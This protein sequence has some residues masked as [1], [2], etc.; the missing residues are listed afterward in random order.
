MVLPQARASKKS[1]YREVTS[2]DVTDASCYNGTMPQEKP[3]R[4]WY[5]FSLR[6]MF[7][8]TVVVSIPL[9]WVGY[10]LN[11]IR[12]RREYRSN[13]PP[14]TTTLV[15]SCGT[16]DPLPLSLRLFGEKPAAN[17]T[18]SPRSPYTYAEAEK[19]FPESAVYK[20]P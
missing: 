15:F 10:S 1:D 20:V 2:V 6:A 12:Q 13:Q 3:R 14:R 16:P 17:I 7:V 8:V 18:W 11:W 9:A 4:R 5:Q 19:L